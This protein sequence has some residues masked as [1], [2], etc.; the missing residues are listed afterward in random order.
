[1]ALH[2]PDGEILVSTNL[3]LEALRRVASSLP[4][5]ALPEPAAWRIRPWA[6]GHVEDGLSPGDAMAK[7][8]SHALVPSWLPLG[9]RAAAA[10]VVRTPQVR[11]VTLVF[12]RPAAELDGVGLRLYQARGQSMPPPGGEEH[13]VSVGG[14][15][16]RWSAQD[17]QV[18][19]V[20][21]GVY[22][23]LTGPAFA[24]STLLRVAD[25]LRAPE[26][27]A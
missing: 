16:G 8:G 5:R 20:S 12:R 24:L 13:A 6:G 15:T 22:R 19:W 9:Y 14:V 26:D 17:H 11:G 21:D 2:T 23:S 27:R 10:E 4:V 25:S 1:M 18:E 7:A 3:P